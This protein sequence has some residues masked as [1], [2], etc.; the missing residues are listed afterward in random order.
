MIN[1]KITHP[2]LKGL[3]ISDFIL[4]STNNGASHYTY[5]TEFCNIMQIAPPSQ[6]IPSYQPPPY[7]FG[8]SSSHQP[9]GSTTQP[10]GPS[11]SVPKPSSLNTEPKF[12]TNIM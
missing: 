3:I 6:G 2:Q 1:K 9:F 10:F 12:T 11:I 8:T 5:P 7:P 4:N